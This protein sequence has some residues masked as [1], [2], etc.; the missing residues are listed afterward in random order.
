[1]FAIALG[2]YVRI[3][4]PL[5]HRKLAAQGNVRSVIVA[6]WLY[7]SVCL[8]PG[9]GGWNALGQYRRAEVNANGAGNWTRFA[10]CGVLAVQTGQFVGAVFYANVLLPAS[11]ATPVL[12][13]RMFQAVR[14]CLVRGPRR[15]PRAARPSAG[16]RPA[17]RPRPAAAPARQSALAAPVGRHRA[18]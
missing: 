15:Q 13:A 8:V 17:R 18:E 3:V 2:R 10:H 4:H 9:L 7:A 16:R 14:R 6:L 11:V 1:M 12:Y 5:R